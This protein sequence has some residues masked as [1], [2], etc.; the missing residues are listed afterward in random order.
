M[1]RKFKR[2]KG[3]LPVRVFAVNGASKALLQ[4]AHTLDISLTGVRL[5]G[6]Q[7]SV[8][9]G[10]VIELEY[11]G[12]R[13]RFRVIWLRKPE[14]AGGSS[15]GLECLEPTKRLWG[16]DLSE[17]EADA[18]PPPPSAEPPVALPRGHRRYTVLSG[19]AEVRNL[20]S[21]TGQWAQV[22]DVS[23]GGC[24]CQTKFPLPQL[25]RVRLLLRIQDTEIDVYGVVK[26]HH[27]FQG[28]GIQFTEFVRPAESQRLKSL[29]EKLQP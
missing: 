5:G 18:G 6:M 8:N 13:A 20:N 15:V 19:G 1:A 17:Q 4:L 23:M 2:V 9:I 29:I 27:P 26:S 11:K 3:V 28:M 7:S 21:E 12:K 16:L 24:Y 25:T 14:D 22:N 10:D